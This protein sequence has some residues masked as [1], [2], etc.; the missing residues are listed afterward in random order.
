MRRL[1]LAA[2]V[3]AITLA[4]MAVPAGA[5][6]KAAQTTVAHKFIGS[7]N[8][9]ARVAA[10]GEQEFAFKPFAVTCEKAK[11]SKAGQATTWPSES[12]FTVVKYSGCTA[13]SSLP[14]MEE[15]E[16]KAKFLTPV[17]LNFNADGYVEAGAEGKLSEGKLQNAGEIEIALSGP[18]KC[19]I[20]VEPGVFPANGGV[21]PGKT[22]EVAK[23]ANEEVKVEKGSKVSVKHK[24]AITTAITK[25]AYELEGEFCEA[26]DKTE[27]KAGTY[28]GDL[29]AELPK[30]N[31]SWE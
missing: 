1:L 22:F 30:G 5:R 19:T 7:E 6:K 27:G 21:K 16:L 26:L 14:G 29:L 15:L 11:S 20:D 4:V 23:Y 10:T 31:L 17:D 12:L 9:E 3:A 2:A 13:T 25:M 28:T 24:V 18:F 8:V